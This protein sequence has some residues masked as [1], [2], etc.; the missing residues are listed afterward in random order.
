[1]PRAIL[2]NHLDIIYLYSPIT[3]VLKR[4]RSIP[5]SLGNNHVYST[6]ES[7]KHLQINLCKALSCYKVYRL[8]LIVKRSK[9]FNVIKLSFLFNKIK[10]SVK[11]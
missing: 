8:W 11:I 5:G 6:Y 10:K 7:F 3:T 4:I 9:M 1:M 2:S